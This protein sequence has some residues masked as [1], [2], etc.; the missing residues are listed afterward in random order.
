MNLEQFATQY[1]SQAEDAGTEQHDAAG[2]RGG[3]RRAGATRGVDREG[4]R[5]NRAYGAF[6]SARRAAVLIP[7]DRIAAGDDRVLQVEPV[8]G[9]ASHGHVQAGYRDLVDV[10]TKLVGRNELVGDVLA[11]GRAGTQNVPAV[12]T[13]GDGPIHRAQYVAREFPG[14]EHEAGDP[15]VVGTGLEGV[16]DDVAKVNGPSIGCA[17]DGAVAIVGEG[18]NSSQCQ[19]ENCERSNT[20]FHLD[21]PPDH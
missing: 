3:R 15:N 19:A 9:V 16:A 13:S 6:R 8:G 1:A 20:K 14:T 18:R 4:F 21:L 17:V 11:A 10:I 7:I 2:L 5:R 12:F